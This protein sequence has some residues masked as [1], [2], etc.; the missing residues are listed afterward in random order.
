MR[1][2][3]L[4]Q[5]GT[6]AFHAWQSTLKDKG[7]PDQ[8]IFDLDPDEGVPFEAVKLAAEDIR[9]R[10]KKTGLISF[11]RLSGG[12]GIHVV[13]PIEPDHD[14]DEVKEFA[15]KFSGHMAREVPDATW[16]I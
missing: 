3:Q 11:P 7:K 5:M 14:W 16:P 10:L 9:N 12:K 4:V 8:I 2:L 13:V 6:M 15:R 1:I